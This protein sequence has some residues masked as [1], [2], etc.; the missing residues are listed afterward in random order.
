MSKDQLHW[1]C[2]FVDDSRGF[3]I[4][5]IHKLSNYMAFQDG[6]SKKM[7][8]QLWQYISIP[9]K[10]SMNDLNKNTSTFRIMAGIKYT[11]YN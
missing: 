3:S 10:K 8:D 6:K 2:S 9:E 7:F 5:E 4:S 1:N 11:R